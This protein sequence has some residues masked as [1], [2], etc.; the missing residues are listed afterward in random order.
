MELLQSPLERERSHQNPPIPP[1]LEELASLNVYLGEDFLCE[2]A[3]EKELQQLFPNTC[4][5]KIIDFKPGKL[6]IQKSP[7]RVGVLFSGGQAPGGHNV[8]AGLFDALK[9]L[10][11]DSILIGFLGGPKGLINNEAI[12]ID[13]EEILPYR[14][15]G[16][17]DLLGSGRDK[18]E[19]EEDLRR[20]QETVLQR[21]LDGL[22]IIGGDDS[23]TNAAH[24]AELFLKNGSDCQVVGVPK[25]IDGDLKNDYIETSF[26]FDTAA[27]VY[28]YIIGNLAR[29]ALSAGKYYFFVKM[30]GR[31]ASHMTLEAALQ[32]HPNMTLISEDIASFGKNLSELVEEMADLICERAKKN[33]NYGLILIPEGVIEFIDD[34]KTL[35]QEVNQILS[36]NKQNSLEVLIEGL[37]EKAR[38]CFYLVPLDIQKQILMERDPHGNVQ[39][40][41]IETERLFITMVEKELENRRQRGEYQGKFNAQPYFCGYEGRSTFPSLFDASYCYALGRVAALLVRDHATGYMACV[42]GLTRPVKHWQPSGIPIVPMMHFEE[43]KGQIKAVVKKALV[44]LEGIPYLNYLHHAPQW[45][46][47]DN[48]RYPGPIQF[49]G[50]IELSLMT[51]MTLLLERSGAPNED[52]HKAISAFNI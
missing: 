3:A 46:L 52:V 26:G 51:T 35:I 48:Y 9:I 22:V 31:S 28:S 23:N 20:T 30:M 17:F 44:D 29:D 24:L 5:R 41:K 14:N 4:K 33:K 39:V 19:R 15:Q 45:R 18:I 43:R 11:Q 42:R 49:F 16:G 6:Q 12:E 7:L 8:I 32:T 37:S 10:H 34:F 21:R 40:S 38:D 50:P 13:E 27:K 25:T 47:E 1:F 36:A 2:A